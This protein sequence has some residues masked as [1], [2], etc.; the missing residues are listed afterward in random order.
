MTEGQAVPQ[1][2]TENKV[3]SMNKV[4]SP[5]LQT[6]YANSI[7]ILMSVYD[8]VITIGQMRASSPDSVLIEQQA[9]VIMSPQHMKTFARLLADKV[10]Q[11][12]ANFGV[13]PEIPP[14][15]P[16]PS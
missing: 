4:E 5:S 6:Y 8:F 14:E 10:V 3:T 13:I 11:Y 1:G 2:H 16:Q 15:P 12:E 9:R 7:D